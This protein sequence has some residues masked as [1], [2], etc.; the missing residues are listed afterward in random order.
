MDKICT[1]AHGEKQV[2]NVSATTGKVE[3]R[4]YLFSLAERALEQAGWRVERIPGSGK[5][6]VRR[7]VK[8]DETHVVSIRTTQDTWIAFPRTSDGDG[9]VTLDDVDFV[10]PVTVD[11][12]DDPKWAAVYMVDAE[13]MRERFDRAYLA[14]KAAGHTVQAGRG[15]WVSMFSTED[16]KI[17]A[18]VGGGIAVGKTPLLRVKISGNEEI[19]V[20]PASEPVTAVTSPLTVAEAKKRLAQTFGVDPEKIKIIIEG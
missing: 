16:P 7:I 9:W 19:E 10:I 20:K 14:R 1:S 6:S 13:E 2:T 11:D 3:L 17:V 15:V 8:G 5:G 4:R 18:S 12:R